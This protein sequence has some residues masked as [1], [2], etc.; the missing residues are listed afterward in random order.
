MPKLQPRKE[1][2][3]LPESPKIHFLTG[4]LEKSLSIV[5]KNAISK[6]SLLLL[7]ELSSFVS[8]VQFIINRQNIA[9]HNIFQ[10]NV[11]LFV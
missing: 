5:F 9:Q 7:T 2:T 11:I 10:S 6:I 1:Q 4:H 8:R 3:Q